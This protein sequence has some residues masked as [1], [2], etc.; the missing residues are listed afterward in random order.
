MK[1]FIVKII[2][3]ILPIIV[4][5]MGLELTL[6]LIPNIYKHKN[7]YLNEHGGEIETLVM[8]SSHTFFGVNPQYFHNNT[9]NLG[10]PAQTLDV[11]YLLLKK[12]EDRLHNLKTIV[13]PISVFT[14]YGKLGAGVEGW[15]MNNYALYYD[16]RT[17]NK[18]SQCFEILARKMQFNIEII[19]QYYFMGE[20][21]LACSDLGWGTSYRPE[22]SKDL[23]ETGNDA[24]KRHT[25][26]D[27]HSRQYED[28]YRENIEA[29]DNIVQ[30]SNEHGVYVV[31]LTMPAYKTYR[32]SSNLDPEIL[33]ITI[34]TS[35]SFAEKN[36]NCSYLNLF[37]SDRFIAEDYYDADHLNYIGAE[38]LSRLLDAYIRNQYRLD[39]E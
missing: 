20:R 13:V 29:L 27:I 17:S 24:A 34:D 1:K 15:R 7:D 39:T 25:D 6:R 2:L 3:F 22:D 38:K 33:T 31:L 16:I 12:Y 30:W 18:L 32:N 28:I 35:R 36:D 19:V 4:I 9:F 21:D 11:D 37:D 23:L 10:H 14:L 26:Y 8:G 5:A